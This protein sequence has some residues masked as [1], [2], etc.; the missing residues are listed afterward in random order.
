MIRSQQE[1]RDE[2]LRVSAQ[3]MVALIPFQMQHQWSP[4]DLVD[5]AIND[6]WRLIKTVDEFTGDRK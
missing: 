6:A 5:M 1:K 4:S 3:V 2:L